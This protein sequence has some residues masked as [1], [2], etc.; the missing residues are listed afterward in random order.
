MTVLGGG[1]GGGGRNSLAE[2]R[3]LAE[4]LGTIRNE[5]HTGNREEKGGKKTTLKPQKNVDLGQSPGRGG[6]GLLSAS[7]VCGSGL[8]PP[9]KG[10]WG[11]SGAGAGRF[12]GLRGCIGVFFVAPPTQQQLWGKV[13]CEVPPRWFEAPPQPW[14]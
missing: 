14:Q 8:F 12:P 13:G 9:K 2:S 4:L 3:A 1:G 7:Q 11:L 6:R 5:L 10:V